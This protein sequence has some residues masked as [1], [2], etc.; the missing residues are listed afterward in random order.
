MSIVAGKYEIYVY[1]VSDKKSILRELF[2]KILYKCSK[3]VHTYTIYVLNS[4]IASLFIIAT[5]LERCPRSVNRNV[6][7]WKV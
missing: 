1:L 7:K 5:T 4:F 3:V 6:A 2:T